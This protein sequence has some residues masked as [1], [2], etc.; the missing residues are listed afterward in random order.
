MASYIGEAEAPP[1]IL[2]GQLGVVHSEAAQDGGVEIVYIDWVLHHVVT[3]VV[4]LA[5]CLAGLDAATCH[6][7]REAAGMMVAAVVGFGKRALGVNGPAKF[8][9]PNHERV[10]Q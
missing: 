7:N 3:V 6:P 9:A 4:G 1:L 10:F 2:I 8:A 5:V